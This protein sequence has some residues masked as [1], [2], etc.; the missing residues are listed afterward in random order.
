MSKKSSSPTPEVAMTRMQLSRYEREQRQRRFIVIGALAVGV[1]TL[2]LIGVAVLQVAVFEPGRAAA[3]VGG[4]TISVKDL[5]RRMRLTQASVNSNALN[6]RSQLAQLGQGDD[7]SAGFLVQY[8]Q[9]QYQQLLSQATAETIAETAYQQLIDDQLIRQEAARRSIAVAPEEVQTDLEASIGLY[10]AT[11]TPFPTESPEPTTVVEG[12]AVVPPTAEP[13]IQPTSIAEDTF[14]YELAKRVQNIAAIGYDENDLRRFIE[15]D[16]L[17]AKLQEAIGAEADSTAQHF[18]FEYVR[19]NVITDALQASADL[20]SGAVDFAGLI[21]RTNAITEPTPIGDG[22]AVDWASD[23][24]VTNQFGA[25]ALNLLNTQALNAVTQPFTST[26]ASGV[27]LMRP[28]G[29]EVRPLAEGELQQVRA[30]K[31]DAWLTGARADETVV[32]K[33]LSPFDLIPTAVR[34]TADAFQQ[35]YALPSQ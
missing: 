25:E 32:V 29:R 5:Q 14:T 20:A 7:P 31:Y 9:Q 28:L 23:R 19:F 2:L 22:R 3:T 35:Q 6:L 17:R 26:T 18:N 10:R 27:F 24:Q 13:R 30:E 4:Q 21:S 8:Y 16:L 34:T 12:T 15:S 11:L 33:L 1:V